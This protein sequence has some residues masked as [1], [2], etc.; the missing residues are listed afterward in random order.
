MAD[1]QISILYEDYA[2]YATFSGGNWI[3]SGSIK[4]ENL[5]TPYLAEIARSASDDPADTQFI[6][7][8]LRTQIIG[9]VA[10]GP[11]TI[12]PSALWR[13]TAYDDDAFET[14]VYASG[15]MEAPGTSVESASLD[16]EDDGFWEGVTKEFDDLFKGIYLIHLP[17]VSIPAKHW[18]IEILDQGNPDGYLNIGKLYL[19][20]RWSP[21]HNFDYGSNALEFEDLTD[22]EE[23]RNGTKFYHDRNIR[24]LFSFAFS[25][26]PDVETIRD[27]YRLA[28]RARR[29]K[30]IVV[31][32]FPDQPDT[33]QREAFIGTLRKLPRLS[34][35]FLDTVNTEFV[36]EESL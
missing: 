19:G 29:S 26:L 15:L 30:Q 18:K 8:L 2:A 24:R 13:V 11:V 33:Y 12:R 23:A 6:A 4:I 27:I 20:K 17:P 31:I 34:R 10:L 28:T 35:A 36:V 1:A 5:R 21:A 14:E 22:E 7:T 16:W 32:P 9:G 25:Y 3:D